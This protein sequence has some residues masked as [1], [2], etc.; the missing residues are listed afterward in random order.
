MSFSPFRC[1]SSCSSLSSLVGFAQLYMFFC[2]SYLAPFLFRL[3]YG[4]IFD[5]AY[6][7]DFF[8]CIIL[9][10]LLLPIVVA[11]SVR[12][13]YLVLSPLVVSIFCS[14]MLGHP[15]RHLIILRMDV[16]LFLIIGKLLYCSLWLLH[17]SLYISALVLAP[18]VLV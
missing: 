10:F 8:V 11:C 2:S 6:F 4:G 5:C 7:L 15:S 3:V 17:I 9:C 13:A 12:V 14:V 18:D 16:H 1:S